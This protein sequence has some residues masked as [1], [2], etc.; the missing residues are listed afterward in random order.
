MHRHAL[1]YTLRPLAPFSHLGPQSPSFPSNHSPFPLI[2]SDNVASP[3]YTQYAHLISCVCPSI[4]HPRSPDTPK[5]STSFLHPAVVSSR[6]P[7]TTLAPSP[8]L[9]QG[10]L[11][12]S[13]TLQDSPPCSPLLSL[14]LPSILQSLSDIDLRPFSLV[15]FARVPSAV[16]DAIRPPLALHLYLHLLFRS[17]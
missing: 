12:P 15:L 11:L 2:A 7:C 9:L 3:L 14:A 5:G 6:R 13:L 1:L 17:T 4:S 8:N 16:L 10:I